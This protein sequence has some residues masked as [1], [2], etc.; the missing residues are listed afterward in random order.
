MDPHWQTFLGP[1]ELTKLSAQVSVL[2][3][4]QNKSSVSDPLNS[5]TRAVA[6]SYQNKGTFQTAKNIVKHRG[7]VGLYSGFNLHLCKFYLLR[8]WECKLTS[9][10]AWY[11][12]YLNLLYDIR[13]QQTALDDIHRRLIAHQ[14]I[15]CA[16]CW[17]TLWCCKLVSDLSHRFCQKHISTELLDGLQRPRRQTPAK[18]TILQ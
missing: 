3:S 11:F 13:K 7:F 16:L 4:D 5:T 10:S 12:R 1:F 14:S 17:G 15:S 18:D 9:C 2:M 6:A 8:G